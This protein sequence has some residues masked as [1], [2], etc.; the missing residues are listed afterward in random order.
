MSERATMADTPA[1][2]SAQGRAAPGKWAKNRATPATAPA[3]PPA[4]ATGTTASHGKTTASGTATVPKIVI[5][6]TNG[7][8][9]TLAIS[10][11]GVNCGWRATMTG[12]HSNWADSGTANPAASQRGT[13]EGIHDAIRLASKTIPKV[14]RT[15]R[16]NPTF[17]AMP[18]S[19]SNSMMVARQRKVR[20]RPRKPPTKAAS[21]T[22]PMTAARRTLGSGP[23]MTT[24]A[25]RPHAAKAPASGRVNLMHLAKRTNPPSTKLQLAPLT[26]VKMCH[27]R[28]LHICLEAFRQRA[29]ISGDHPWH[30]T[31]RVRRQPP[32]R[33]DELPPHIEG[34]LPDIK[35]RADDDR[36]RGSGQKC[37]LHLSFPY[38]LQRSRRSDVLPGP[39][40]LP[41]ISTDHHHVRGALRHGTLGGDFNQSRSNGPSRSSGVPRHRDLNRSSGDLHFNED[42]ASPCHSFSQRPR[43]LRV[44]R[45]STTN[46]HCRTQDTCQSKGCRNRSRPLRGC[47]ITPRPCQQQEPRQTQDSCQRCGPCGV[48]QGPDKSNG[49]RNQNRRDQPQIR[50]HW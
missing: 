23:T 15:D 32:R 41:A 4:T 28:C 10:A 36:S 46:S 2:P 24:K 33:G 12:P 6:A 29:R 47:P 11:Y 39:H 43:F 18:G 17:A 48:D 1:G 22:V 35:S 9:T 16:R 3:H 21:P 5:G 8:A 44:G 7:P 14:A 20:D 30:Q 19:S 38:S 50:A 27:S 42:T 37:R 31:G 13:I 25:A 49:P 26:A 45:D 40:V 34:G